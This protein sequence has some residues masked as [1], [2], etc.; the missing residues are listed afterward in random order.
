MERQLDFTLS[1]KFSGLPDLIIKIKEEGMRFIIILVGFAY[2]LSIANYQCTMY[3]IAFLILFYHQLKGY[4]IQFQDPTIS[5]N[6]TDYPPFSRGKENDVFM[7]W[8]NSSDIIYSRVLFLKS[9]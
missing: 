1:E 9:V 2:W 5:G 3:L 4:C 8:P 6:E 7:K